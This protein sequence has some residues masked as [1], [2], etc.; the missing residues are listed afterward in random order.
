VSIGKD[1]KYV[2]PA[3]HKLSSADLT[4]GVFRVSSDFVNRFLASKHRHK[5][6]GLTHKDKYEQ[7]S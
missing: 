7:L 3:T 5:F 2:Y 1:K 6:D 4:G